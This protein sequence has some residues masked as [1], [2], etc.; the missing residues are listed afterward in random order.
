MVVSLSIV[1]GLV[2]LLTPF[3]LPALLKIYLIIVVTSILLM[4]P[5]W[6]LHSMNGIKRW[7]VYISAIL[8]VALLRLL[9]ANQVIDDL[10]VVS[11][12][13][14]VLLL[15][16]I[17]L[18]SSRFKRVAWSIIAEV[19]DHKV[20]NMAVIQYMSKTKTKPMHRKSI[21]RNIYNHKK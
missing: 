14:F 5:H 1:L 12:I 4:I 18:Y 9:V 15:L 17:I 6:F 16:T 13:L 8:M 10:L 20:W 11:L 19:N 21:S 7:I 2:Y 3:S